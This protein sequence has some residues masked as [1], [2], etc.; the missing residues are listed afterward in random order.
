[1]HFSRVRVR[2]S[3]GTP[4]CF[5]RLFSFSNVTNAALRW[6][7]RTGVVTFPKVFQ[8]PHS[9]LQHN[10]YDQVL[11]PKLPWKGFL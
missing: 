10:T 2:A 11:L 8:F 3:A 7:T 6:L 4:T 5:C 1:M 9:D